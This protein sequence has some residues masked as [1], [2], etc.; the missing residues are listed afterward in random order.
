MKNSKIEWT[1]HTF[2]AWWGCQKVSPGCQ[3]CYAEA[4]GNH[5]L[6][7]DIWGPPETT[8]RRI[9]SRDNW[10]RPHEWNKEAERIGRQ[11]VFCGSMCDVF[12]VHPQLEPE[13]EVLWTTIEQTPNLD[14]LL[15]T[16]RPENIQKLLPARWWWMNND[17]MGYGC[18]QNVFLGVTAENQE[19]FNLRW[20]I[21]RDIAEGIG[22]K[23][24]FISCEP[25][26]GPIDVSEAEVHEEIPSGRVVQRGVDWII[27]GGE[28]GPN[29]RPMWS[30]WA[31]DIRDTCDSL[32]IPFFFKQM[33]GKGKDKGGNVL[34][35]E[36]IQQFPWKPAE[37]VKVMQQL[38]MF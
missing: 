21:L 34:D 36:V 28:S 26:L 17:Y 15:L 6:G 7:Y 30:N 35:G 24:T 8:Q 5:R 29:A 20:P 18:P 11:T 25:L 23:Y 13:Q 14:W 31:T 22:V 38:S 19:M 4:F 1:D 16:K 3:N 37:P 9:L 27:V 33:G 2:N 12:E 10:N 32:S